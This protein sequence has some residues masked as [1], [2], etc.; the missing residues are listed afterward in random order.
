MQK[1]VV[2][3]LARIDL[4]GGCKVKKNF[5][6]NHYV[7]II[8]VLALIPILILGLILTIDFVDKWSDSQNRHFALTSDISKD[9]Q[10]FLE[11]HVL[12]LDTFAKQTGELKVEPFELQ[13]VMVQIV[14]NYQGFSEIYVD[15]DYYQLSS[16]YGE[17]STDYCD[18]K[19]KMLFNHITYPYFIT[20]TQPYIS[21]VETYK[22]GYMELFIAIPLRN[23]EVGFFGFVMGSLDME[24]LHDIL[25]NSKIYPS[26]YTAVV[27]SYDQIIYHPGDHALQVSQETLPVL[28]AIKERGSGT[29]E[30]YSPITKRDEIASFI[31]IYDLGWGMWV[32]APRNEVMAPLYRAAGLSFSVILLSALVIIVIRFLLIHNITQPLRILDNASQELSRGN[33]EYRVKYDSDDIPLEL[34]T[35]GEKFNDMAVNLEQNNILLKK[36]SDDLENRVKQRTK[37]LVIKNKELSA[38]YAVAS[39][40]SSTKALTDVLKDVLEEIMNLFNVEVASIYLSGY[41]KNNFIH[42]IWRINE[43]DVEKMSYTVDIENISRNII[44]KSLPIVIEDLSM[45]KDN[46]IQGSWASELES[47]ISV[48]IKNKNDIAGTITLASKEKSRFANKEQNLLQAISNQLG[49]VISNVSLF[50]VITQDHNRHLAVM[51]S[52][53]DGLILFDYKSKVTYA[54]PVFLKLFHLQDI[55]WNNMTFWDL[56]NIF[57][58]NSE[59]DIPFNQLWKDFLNQREE[60]F[61]EVV[62]KKNDKT[63]YYLMHGFPVRSKGNFIGYGFVVRDITR[64]KEI[65]MLKNSILST[66][67][68]ELRTPLTTIRGSAESLLREDVTWEMEEEKEF[69]TAIVDESKRLRELIDNIM[70]M[71]KIESGALKLDIHSTDLRT[72]IRRVIDR[73]KQRY[74][75]ADIK[76]EILTELPFVEID[77]KRIEQVLYNLIENGIKYSS[78]NESIIIMVEVTDNNK[79]CV[80]VSVKDFGI[81]IDPQHHKAVFERFYRVDSSHTKVVTGSGVGLSIAKGIIGAHGG[82][83]RVESELGKGSK[84]IFTLPC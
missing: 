1:C 54:N 79:N 17:V 82:D 66:V 39:A 8:A 14:N 10:S 38:L 57:T 73:I 55:D 6:I 43:H 37:E 28:K 64:D 16:K 65:D 74:P 80:Q 75:K 59:Y 46:V 60:E 12:A 62:F 4:Q 19:K 68:H 52:M 33:L 32:A 2:V 61:R 18:M 49:V 84:F 45:Y 34:L 78:P 29:V 35:L 42:T 5:K 51:N 58:A 71:S 40:V 27:D 76:K 41:D 24:Y 81:G 36:H 69:I 44:K 30:Y 7:S 3:F 50:N 22:D 23:D 11:L 47:L 9:L 67:S 70:D 21:P 48:P 77:E 20:R 13:D 63:R 26:S 15:S 53:H 56:E 83:I 72:V 31:T 25:E